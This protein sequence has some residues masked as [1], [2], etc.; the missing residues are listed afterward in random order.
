ME[1]VWTKMMVLHQ[2]CKQSLGRFEGCQF[3]TMLFVDMVFTQDRP[4]LDAK[5]TLCIGCHP[6]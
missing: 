1:L 6:H 5:H 4:S 3:I 2:I